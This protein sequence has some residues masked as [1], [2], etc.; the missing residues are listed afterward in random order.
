[1]GALPLEH[2]LHRDQPARSRRPDR[3]VQVVTHVRKQDSVH[4]LEH[5]GADIV[6]LRPQLLFRDTRP[7]ANRTLQVLSLH[8]LLHCH[9][10]N[11][12]ER[13]P[14][15]MAFAMSR[16]TL[17]QRRIVSDTGLL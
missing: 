9:G 2:V 3:H 8:H 6:S 1:M 5:P 15:I 7:E 4:V 14:G 13:H 16:R 12:V 10:R 17:D 11:D